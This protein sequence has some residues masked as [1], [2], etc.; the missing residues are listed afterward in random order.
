[1]ASPHI[2][3]NQKITGI[4]QQR[5]FFLLNALLVL[6]AI[7]KYRSSKIRKLCNDWIEVSGPVNAGQRFIPSSQRHQQL[8]VPKMCC[9][10]VPV[11]FDRALKLCLGTSPVP[12]EAELDAC[13]RGM[14]L[15]K[16]F[17]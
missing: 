7:V 1:M 13:Q 10:I 9:D 4:Q 17:V 6:S 15:S 14:P 12:I 5:L 16:S 11:Q 2:V 3:M 8:G